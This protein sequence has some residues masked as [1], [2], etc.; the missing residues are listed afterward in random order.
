MRCYYNK[1]ISSHRSPSELGQ[2]SEYFGTPLHAAIK[3]HRNELACTIIDL[4]KKE[5]LKEPRN[6]YK[7]AVV[8]RNLSMLH[9]LVDHTKPIILDER[10]SG[11]S[12]LVPASRPRCLKHCFIK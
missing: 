10:K 3:S 2:D 6:C 12:V 7:A 9:H 4:M 1:I 11:M 5:N 8:S